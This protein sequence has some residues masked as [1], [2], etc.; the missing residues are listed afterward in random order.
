[1]KP[2]CSALLLMIFLS[3]ASCAGFRSGFESIPYVGDME[4]APTTPATKEIQLPGV[5]LDISL[6]NTIRTSDVQVV[7]LVPMSVDPRN[8]PSFGKTGRLTVNLK[9]IPTDSDF[10]FDPSGAKA[11]VDGHA[12]NPIIVRLIDWKKWQDCFNSAACD[13]K[14]STFWSDAIDKEIALTKDKNYELYLIF[15]CPVP[16]PERDIRL[17]IGRALLNPR[18]PDIPTIRFMKVRWRQ[19]YT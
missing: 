16:T 12:F 5:K 6:N 17:D 19:G 13:I 9:I 1:M 10:V 15:D 4:P 11:T 8:K 18:F 2:C 7:L 14:D 3:V